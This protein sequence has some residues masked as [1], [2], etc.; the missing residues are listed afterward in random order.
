MTATKFLILPVILTFAGTGFKPDG[1]QYYGLF[2][3]PFFCNKA[4]HLVT[5]SFIFS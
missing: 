1:M 4:Y 2:L 5:F 3:F